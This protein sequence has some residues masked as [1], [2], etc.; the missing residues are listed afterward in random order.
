MLLDKPIHK[1]DAAI[2]QLCAAINAYEQGQDIVAITLA[3]AAEEILGKMCDRK[4]I[5]NA[6]EQIANL[7][8]MMQV[9]DKLEARIAFL[10]DIRNNL[11][12][13]RDSAEDWFTISELESFVMIARALANAKSLALPLTKQM[14]TF[15]MKP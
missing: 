4:G 11:K 9:S 14:K 1:A 3:G 6:V 8:P 15:G 5:P 12:H 13:A 7:A 10:N 2:T